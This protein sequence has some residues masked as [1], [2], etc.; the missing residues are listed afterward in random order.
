MKKP[1]KWTLWI[2]GLLLLALV[3]FKMINN[4]SGAEK[5]A[6]EKVASRSITESVSTSGKIFPETEIAIVPEFSGQI[7]DLKVEEGDTVKKGQLLAVISNR[8]SITAPAAGVVLSLNIKK[9]ESVSGNNFSAG[10]EMMI[11]AELSSWELRVDI[12]ENDIIK[13][14]TGDSADVT[15]D[16][17]NSKKFRGTV[18]SIA[19]TTKASKS[20]LATSDATTYEVKIKL[21]T[22]SYAGLSG[23]AVPFRPGM[24][25][26]AEIK[27]NKKDNILSVPIIAVGARTKGSGKSM[28]DLKKE[29][30]NKDEVP[31]DDDSNELE[32]VVFVLQKDGT[33]EKVVVQ[34][35]IQDMNYIEIITGLKAGDEVVT[36]P[37]S[38]ISQ[39]LKS[40]MK[41]KV[42]PKS[43][44][45]E[46]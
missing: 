42:I 35:G 46:K 8:T 12:G 2:A 26:R 20:P 43:K 36:G 27:T 11:I 22:A 41:V 25:A 31:A 44:L 39:K 1:L 6:V 19:N 32:E 24:N 15:V 14:K 7:T 4:G 21:D 34:S 30:T 18:T 28:E 10:T 3:F 37:Y 45:F 38:A 17:Y 9:G 29:E 23:Q 13:I 5:V 33:V 16:A 40:G